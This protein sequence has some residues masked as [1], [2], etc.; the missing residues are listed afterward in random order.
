VKHA[1]EFRRPEAVQGLVRQIVAESTRPAKFMEVCGTHTHSAARFG[2][3]QMLPDPLRLLSGPGCPVCVT[4]PGEVDAMLDLAARPE[5]TLTTFGDMVRVPGHRGSLATARAHGAEVRVIYSPIQAVELARA[6]PGREIVFIGVGFETTAPTVAAAIREA[7]EQRLPNFSVLCCHKLI[8]PAMAILLSSDDVRL[9]G[10][11]CPGHVSVIIGSEA[12]RPLAEQFH[13]PF[14]VAGFEPTDILL[15]L[16]AL[17]RQVEAGRA[18]VENTYVRTVRPEGNPQARALMAEVFETADSLWRGLG[19]LPASGLQVRA[20]LRDYD[21]AA[22]FGLVIEQG[23]EH[24]GCR[25]G[26][27]LRGARRPQQCPSFGRACTPEDP[28]G[29][30]MVSSEGACSAAYRYG[31]RNG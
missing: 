6:E 13:R 15:G 11:L 4:A 21:A 1:D 12:Y 5:V 30:C 27:V 9:D 25:C 7:A 17:V 14:V 26:E 22:K 24:E 2:L 8:P 31:E 18:E 16:L 29:P 28:L 19:K 10:F 3:P 23:E 20:E